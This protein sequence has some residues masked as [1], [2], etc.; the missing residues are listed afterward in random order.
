MLG[1]GIDGAI[2]LRAFEWLKMLRE[3]LEFIWSSPNGAI[4]PME[5]QYEASH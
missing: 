4:F 5:H 2:R 3:S 1:L